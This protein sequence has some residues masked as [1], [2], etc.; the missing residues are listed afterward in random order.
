ME[1]QTLILVDEK[2]KFLGYSQKEIC[3]TGRG[4]RHRAFVTALFDKQNRI[5][6]QR[7]KHRLF[8][9]LWDLTAISH[10][11][12]TKSSDETYQ[13][14][15]DRALLKELGVKNVPVKKV[16]EFNYYARD[17]KNCENEYCAVLVGNYDG[18]FSANKKETYGAKWVKFSDFLKDIKNNPKKY[19]PW[20]RLAIKQLTSANAQAATHSLLK[21]E[22]ANFLKIFEPYA[23]QYFSK[24]IKEGSNYSPLIRRF[25]EDLADF[26]AGGKKLRAFLVYLGSRVGGMQENSS[27]LPLALATE[28][29]HNFLLIHDDIIDKSDRRHGKP[30]IH[31]RYEKKFGAHYGLS[32]AMLIGDIACFEAFGLINSSQI[33]DPLKSAVSSKFSEVLLETGYGEALDVENSYRKPKIKD[34]WQ[35]TDLKTARYSFVGPITIGALVSGASAKQIRAIENFG[36]LVGKA[37]QLQDDILGVFGDEKV[38]GKST[39]S[40]MREGKNTIL[41]HKA[42]EMAKVDGKKQILRVWG[43][44]KANRKELI[45]IQKIICES[46]VLSWC[47]REKSKLVGEAVRI[48]DRISADFELVQIFVQLANY[49]ANRVN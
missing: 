29:F 36:K 33:S 30:A 10:P 35:V 31:M 24:K 6:L 39:L 43:S 34:I 4:I 46:G 20:A 18:P 32:Q 5:L 21:I 22:L 7:R 14:A 1:D 27:I 16:G 45:Q 42:R 44:A 28:L 9:N 48:T 12:H 8:N 40:D 3:H 19:T 13:Q 26:V 23:K 11:L 25:Y 2:D 41:I 47:E 49:S 37:Y 38:L 17:G 15:S